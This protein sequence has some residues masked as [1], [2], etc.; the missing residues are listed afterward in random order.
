MSVWERSPIAGPVGGKSR[1]KAAGVLQK[2]LLELVGL[3][4]LVKHLHWNV[5]GEGFLEVHRHLD[6]VHGMLSGH[7]DTVAERQVALGEAADGRPTAVAEYRPLPYRMPGFVHVGSVVS[8]MVEAL[9]GLDDRLRG[10]VEAVEGHDRVTQDVLV[11]VA[12]DVEKELW[13]WQ[14]QQG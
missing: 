11:G 6:E 14:A 9:R 7:A 3:S 12:R 13:M 8:F 2:A 10:F 1:A 5:V 4:L